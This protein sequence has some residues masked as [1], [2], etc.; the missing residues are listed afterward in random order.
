MS[1][2]TGLVL[3]LALTSSRGD[4]FQALAHEHSLVI[5]YFHDTTS[6]LL[7]DSITASVENI[8]FRTHEQ[9][10]SIS[11]VQALIDSLPRNLN[12]DK[13]EN[14][15]P[16]KSLS[17]LDVL[18]EDEDG[19]EAEEGL[20]IA[21]QYRKSIQ[22]QRLGHVKSRMSA[23][24]MNSSVVF[25]HSFDLSGRLLEQDFNRDCIHVIDGGFSDN[26]LEWQAHK[27]GFQLFHTLK[28]YIEAMPGGKLVRLLL[29]KAPIEITSIALPLLLAHIRSEELPVVIMVTIQSWMSQSKSA[30]ISLQRM[31]D[32]VMQVQGFA[33]R[34]TYPQP[35]EFQHLHGLLMLP[36]V[37]VATGAAALGGGH[38]ADMTSTKHPLAQ[39]Y[40][41]KRDRRKLHIPLLHIPP[42][43]SS[44][45]RKTPV[46]ITQSSKQG[47]GCGTIGE[48]SVL[49][50]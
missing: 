7:P 9:G 31:S 5:P 28:G 21:W 37:S 43:N 2:F 45:E 3:H 17:T 4:M 25:C 13:P 12:W 44:G 14:I 41:L 42:E 11:Q 23:N 36:K 8:H 1:F 22:D 47:G 39:V 27:M 15:S 35:P 46:G 33:S 40:G 30:L 32:V 19:D 24:P 10:A 49:D 34:L 29:Y 50:F 6:N 20:R 48:S 16:E 18:D 26:E 38:F